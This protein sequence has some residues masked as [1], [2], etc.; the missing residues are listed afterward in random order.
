MLIHLIDR[1]IK[2][3][4]LKLTHFGNDKLQQIGSVAQDSVAIRK[5]LKLVSFLNHLFSQTQK[6]I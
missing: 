3:Y 5:L 4:S 2:L 1:H 6:Q